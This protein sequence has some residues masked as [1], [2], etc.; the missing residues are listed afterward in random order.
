VPFNFGTPEFYQG[1]SN[2]NELPI[3]KCKLREGCLSFNVLS[4]SLKE[5]KEVTKNVFRKLS[6]IVVTLLVALTLAAC[7]S[8]ATNTPAP[9]ATTAPAGAATTA[10]AGAATTAPAA[11]GTVSLPKVTGKITLWHAYGSGGSGEA[12]ALTKAL[13]EFKKDNPDA[14]VEALDVPFDQIFNKF[15]TEAATGAGPDLMVVPSDSLGDLVRAKVLEPVD[16]KIKPYLESYTPIAVEGSKVD[17]KM[18][19]VPGTPKAV[20]MFYNKDKVKTV[21]KTTAE[22]LAAQKAGTKF[23]F[24]NGIYH[25]FGLTGAYGGKLLDASGKCTATA[26]T[27]FADAFKFMADMKAAGAQLISDGDKAGQAFST[28][29]ADAIIEGP[30]KTADF[31]KAF[32]DKLGVAPI[33]SAT[34]PAT[35]LT[36]VDGFHINSSSKNKDNAINFALY[37]SANPKI[38]QMFVDIGQ[39]PWLKSVTSTDPITQGFAQAVATGFPRPQVPELANFWANFGDAYTKATESGADATKA[40]ADACAAMDKAN[41]K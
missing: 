15:R 26:N 8:A 9:A 16:D 27:G 2:L 14:A 19:M 13:A 22:M 35:P 39:V 18:Y 36:G 20:A 11:G 28:G 37:M 40:V 3:G 1:R 34:G 6:L 29:Q 38:V 17:G 31:K 24:N 30:W 5:E 21:P 7:G 32:G 12:Q 25:Q 4:L 33:P 41:K 10:P 23:A